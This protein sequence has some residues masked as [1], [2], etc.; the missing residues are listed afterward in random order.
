MPRETRLVPI[1][2]AVLSATVHGQASH[3]LSF[4]P[5][6]P[7]R[8][9][10]ISR[11]EIL[12]LVPPG[13]Q[14]LGDT[15]TVEALRLESMTQYVDAAD[16]DRFL[17]ELHYD[18]LRSRM[19]PVGG[20]WLE[21][22]ASETEMAV[23]RVLL[24]RHL[25]VLEAQFVDRPDLRASRA[26]MTRGL[27]GSIRPTL[28]E[29][30]VAIGDSWSTDVA[31]ALSQ[32][33][34]IGREEGVPADGELLSNANAV[35]DSALIRGAETLYYV[36]VRGSFIPA[37]FTA[38]LGDQ[39]TVVSVGGSLAAMMIWSS[40]WNAFVSSASRVVLDMDVRDPTSRDPGSTVRFDI[41]TNTQVRR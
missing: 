26:H 19:R 1:L 38:T 40:T 37:N 14:Q 17:I 2:L 20:V 30:P 18:S 10:Q 11:S 13:A 6:P 7:V 15:L 32:L 36:T 9:N 35:L 29:G 33:R 28:P 12:M 8:V 22:E 39:E 23:V 4:N 31:F 24:D 34:S 5:K 41:T 27:A 21:L 16:T 25:R 3:A